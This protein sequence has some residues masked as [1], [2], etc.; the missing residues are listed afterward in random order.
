MLTYMKVKQRSPKESGAF[1]AVKESDWR[2]QMIIF[3]KSGS[4]SY[5]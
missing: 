5:M 1:S 3:R 4:A 2:E